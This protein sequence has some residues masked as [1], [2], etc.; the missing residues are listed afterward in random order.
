MNKNSFL[1]DGDFNKSLIVWGA[2]ALVM[3]VMQVCFPFYTDDW[4]YACT[5]WKNIVPDA[6]REYL[7]MNSRLTGLVL[8][9]VFSLSPEWIIDILNTVGYLIFISLLFQFAFGKQW[10]KIAARWES[11]VVMWWLCMNFIPRCDHVFLW[12][13]G[14]AFYLWPMIFCFVVI[15]WAMRQITSEERPETPWLKIAGLSV[16]AFLGGMGNYNYGGIE[17]F[18]LLIVWAY[19]LKK[20]SAEKKKV[21]ALLV[22]V[23]IA[24]AIVVCSPGPYH[25]VEYMSNIESHGDP[26][27]AQLQTASS[28]I[29]RFLPQIIVSLPLAA[30][31][32]A[33]F[34]W[35]CVRR[36]WT[37]EDIFV[38]VSFTVLTVVSALPIFLTPVKN[39]A[40]AY[41][42]SFV[43]ACVPLLRVLLPAAMFSSSSWMKKVFYLA[44]FI[45]IAS[46]IYSL[47][48]EIA[49][50]QWWQ[51][52]KTVMVGAEGKDV[53]VPYK[54]SSDSVFA[55]DEGNGGHRDS[56]RKVLGAS[57]VSESR[58]R[59]CYEGTLN[60]LHLRG[61]LTDGKQI[62][63]NG[64]IPTGDLGGELA[65]FPT[66][67]EMGR[68]LIA[69]PSDSLWVWWH[70]RAC[71]ARW[72]CFAK[73]GVTREE[74]LKQG[75]T[76]SE[77]IVSEGKAV[78]R[79]SV[80]PR[81]WS[82]PSCPNIWVSSA[83]DG[84]YALFNV[85]PDWK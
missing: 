46:W 22:V 64:I 54:P 33:C 76:I 58:Q 32:C 25:R 8:T 82:K 62:F 6:L 77:P 55:A 18:V 74:L 38:I 63:L 3:Y 31:A 41:A 15:L 66:N 10:K 65:L 67:G 37:R 16:L 9:R 75:Y 50:Y 85:Y 45:P 2:V 68:L 69:Y 30:L 29:H 56:I 19:L 80:Y 59:C 13:C 26:A 36:L 70:P 21:F 20:G 14:T 48:C 84:K 72:F 49:T 52:C 60:H 61:Q 17:G 42:L 7:S 11:Q 23:T 24:T 35:R 81:A 83:D 47:P 78:M 40:R 39:G 57:S 43:L 44:L 27:M 79:W 51:K 5:T 73:S 71:I 53:L 34:L 28:R 1:N 4:F 12:T